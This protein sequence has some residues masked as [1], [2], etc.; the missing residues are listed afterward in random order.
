MDVL[1]NKISICFLF[2]IGEM[3]KETYVFIII[4]IKN[5]KNNCI[6]VYYNIGKHSI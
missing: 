2:L 6:W 4:Y 3:K 1:F 5:E